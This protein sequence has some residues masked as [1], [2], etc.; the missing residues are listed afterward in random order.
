LDKAFK[1][2]AI[3]QMKTFLFAGHDTS[4]ST[5]AYAYLLLSQNPEKLAKARA[6]L[7]AVFGTDSSWTGDLIKQN[8][9]LTNS[10]PYILAVIKETLR[11]FPPALTVREGKGT[12]TYEGIPYN[13]DGYQVMVISHTMHRNPSFFPSPEE[14]IPE[15]WLPAPDNFQEI[16]KDV[17][18]P[19]E[20]GP[21]D[22]IGQQLAVLEMKIILSMTLRDFDFVE[23]YAAWDR[24]LGREKPGDTLDGRRGMFG[25]RAYQHLIASAKP[26]DGLPGRFVRRKHEA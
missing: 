5:I 6:E 25:Q 15:R 18:R 22:C 4:S 14:F 12:I 21:R 16:P 1:A 13:I 8:P 3:D 10:V 23:D 26:V 9:N 20:K 19:F 11:L 17:W 7:D 2:V 24:M